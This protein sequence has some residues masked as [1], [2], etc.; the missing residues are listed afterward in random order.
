MSPI[1]HLLAS[2]LIAAHVTNEQR[3][4]RLITLAGVLPDLDGL[5]VVADIVNSWRGHDTLYYAQYHH[6]LLHG[7]FG[8]LLLTGALS[9]FARQRWR[10]LGA[11]LL[12]FHLHLVCDFVG[13]RGLTPADVWPIHYLGP[14]SQQP[15]WSWSGQW[16]LDGWTNRLITVG[17]FLPALW[18]PVRLGH[19]VVGVFNRRADAAVV[20]VLRKWHGQ[21]RL[22][23]R[24]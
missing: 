12:V 9:A 7:L 6:L 5:G 20:A 19:S 4:V 10:T 3:D 8:A 13:A 22:F 11:S 15:M 24:P 16:R 17:L 14:F 18:I 21:L 23:E 1:T 2:W